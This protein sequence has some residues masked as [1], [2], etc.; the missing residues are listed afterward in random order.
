MADRLELQGIDVQVHHGRAEDFVQGRRQFDVATGRSVSELGQFCSWMHGLL[1][2]E[3]NHGGDDD[4]T[5]A[6]ASSSPCLLYW[7]GGDVD[8]SIYQYTTSDTPVSELIPSLASS[9]KRVLQFPQ[10]AVSN[11]AEQ[12]LGK[13]AFRASLKNQKKQKKS[14]TKPNNNNST[15]TSNPRKQ[16]AARG[17]WK[18]SRRTSNDNEE[19]TGAAAST[20]KQRGYQDFQ[21]YDSTTTSG[22]T[23]RDWKPNVK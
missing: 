2:R 22:G 13:A 15:T 6:T 16:K 5:A 12:H 7:I 23:S 10:S 19:G 21:R 9:D 14:A 20:P 8:Q 11:I 1:K 18:T 4:S 17:S 3:D